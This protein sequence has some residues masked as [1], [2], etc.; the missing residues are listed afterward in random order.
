[1]VNYCSTCKTKLATI[2]HFQTL[3]VLIQ[4]NQYFAHHI[5]LLLQFSIHACPHTNTLCCHL[6]PL[7]CTGAAGNSHPDHKMEY[8][9][10]RLAVVL[11]SQEDMAN[12]YAACGSKG[13]LK[14]NNK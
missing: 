1:M 13:A 9:P 4:E 6:Y 12:Y 10:R 11:P 14:D 2:H 8:K 7:F 3:G 5:Q